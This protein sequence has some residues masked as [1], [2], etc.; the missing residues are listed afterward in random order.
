MGTDK[1]RLLG[2]SR[3][4]A[5][6]QH[7][8]R[9]MVPATGPRPVASEVTA[10]ENEPP[11]PGTG[12]GVGSERGSAHARREGREEHILMQRC[13]SGSGRTHPRSGSTSRALPPSAAAG[14]AARTAPH[15]VSAALPPSFLHPQRL[16][17]G[18]TI[19]H[20]P[21]PPRPAPLR[22][23]GPCRAPLAFGSAGEAGAGGCFG[24]LL[25]RRLRDAGAACAGAGMG[26][27]GG[28]RC[29]TCGSRNVSY[30]TSPEY[31]CYL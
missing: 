23:E 11:S 15:K 1:G 12:A 9:A 22:P 3:Q 2:S 30:G 13:C 24:V 5:E 21:E 31:P 4:G 17:V 10:E 14:S 19:P 16:R 27:R 26:G 20:P 6:E 29:V 7:Q 8:L 25:W 18:G 28:P